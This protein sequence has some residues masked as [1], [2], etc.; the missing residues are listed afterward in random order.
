MVTDKYI[1]NFAEASLKV[2][3][4]FEKCKNHSQKSL[5]KSKHCSCIEKNGRIYNMCVNEY[6]GGI[7]RYESFSI[8]AEE[9]AIQKTLTKVKRTR[10]KFNIF[11]VRVSEK[12]N[13]FLNSKPC[14]DCVS[15]MKKNSYLINKVYY[16]YDNDN[17]VIEKVQNLKSN[18]VSIGNQ[19]L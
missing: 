4:I 15:F 12:N 1:Y 6:S 11:I 19:Q 17:Y 16:T 13:N 2:L 5:M 8:H 14:V 7:N 3:K 10:K 18:H 9:N